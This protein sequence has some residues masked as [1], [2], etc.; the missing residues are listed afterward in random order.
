MEQQGLTLIADSGGTKTDWALCRDGKLL[1]RIASAGINPVHQEESVVRKTLETVA[2]E[3]AGGGW[4]VGRV[5]FYGAGCSADRVPMMCRLIEELFGCPSE[6][7]SDLLGAAR[8]L[9]GVEE[10]IACILGTGSNSGL[11]DGKDIVAHVPSLGYILGDEGSGAVLGR[12]FLN[13]LFKGELPDWMK[14][15]FGMSEGEAIERVY[16]QPNA[17]RFLASTSQYI[18]AHVSEPQVKA[19]VKDNFRG[20]FRKNIS[21]YQR[22]DLQV[23][24]VGGMAANYAEL[25]RETAL[26]E[27]FKVGRILERPMEGLVAM[28]G[29]AIV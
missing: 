3:L 8:A 10:G 14:A 16:R 20:F 13:A 24:A 29:S 28:T 15:D 7:A 22:P 11:Y 27:G 12:M 17:N 26:E 25:F 9:C 19:L 18:R 4:S 2:S 6:V 21:K 1:V 23:N 5:M